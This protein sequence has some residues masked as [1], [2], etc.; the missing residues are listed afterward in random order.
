[1]T[2]INTLKSF[3]SKSLNG[4]INVPGD[5]SISQRALIFASLCFGSVKIRGLLESQDVLHTL[6]SLREL[7]IKIELN[8]DLCKVFGNGGVF[9]TPKKNLN[10]GNSGTGARLMMGMLASR[11]IT[12]TFEGDQSLSKRPMLR[13]LN[14]LERFGVKFKHSDGKLPVTIEKNELLIPCSINLKLGSAQVKSAV[15]LAALNINGKT[16]I[17]D[18]LP[19][20]D[21]TEILL[22][23]LGADIQ[24]KSSKKKNIITINGP[25]ILERKD[26]DIP[27]DFSSAAFIIVAVT[28]CKNSEVIIKSLGV[29]FFRTGLLDILEKMNAKITV[30]EKW[31]KNGEQI[32]DLK[33]S[34]SNLIGCKIGGKISTRAI[35]EYPILFVAASYA[36]GCTEFTDLEELKFKESDRLSVMAEA[37]QKSGVKIKLGKNSI[38]IY[39]QKNQKG[40]VNIKTYDDHRIAM[41][42]I[43]FGLVSEKP[44]TID[45]TKM[46]ETSFPDFAGLMKKLGAKIDYVQK[47]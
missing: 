35:D 38:K 43:I 9:T 6:N 36:D 8:K 25:V 18:F 40:G 7:G 44:I 47:P 1:M 29:N 27:G 45:Q 37:L 14:P 31:E 12:A 46:I 26:I 41:S 3:K 42:M 19:S 21:H 39:G 28:L 2:K 11:G 10:F 24:V 32:A 17:N 33:I 34:S 15:L 4:I 22:K 16:E 23:Y 5:K 13:V 20:R 30:I